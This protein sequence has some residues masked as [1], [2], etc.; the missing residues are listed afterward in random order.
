MFRRNDRWQPMREQ[1]KEYPTGAMRCWAGI[2]ALRGCS[3]T[4]WL[5]RSIGWGGC[6]WYCSVC[7]CVCVCVSSLLS[8]PSQW[9]ALGES[10][11]LWRLNYWALK[12]QLTGTEKISGPEITFKA[13]KAKFNLTLR[14]LNLC[15]CVREGGCCCQCA[16]VIMS[17]CVCLCFPVCV[18]WCVSGCRHVHVSIW[19]EMVSIWLS[20]IAEERWRKG[21]RRY[22]CLNHLARQILEELAYQGL[23]VPHCQYTQKILL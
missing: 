15:V 13:I 6:S 23:L 21:K 22:Q 18:C 10:G 8:F 20:L 3:P 17:M 12:Y 19:V 7:V 16:C 2:E 14:N 5:L 11:P 4:L 9:S 1:W